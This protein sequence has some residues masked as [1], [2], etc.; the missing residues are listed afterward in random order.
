M[1]TMQ[2]MGL[3]ML[4]L[5]AMV[6]GAEA[7]GLTAAARV[8]RSGWA[9]NAYTLSGVTGRV[10]VHTIF[11]QN[12]SSSDLWLHVFDATS[13]PANNTRPA[14]TAVKILAGSGGGY[15][16][17]LYGAPFTSGV[18][19]CTSSTDLTLTNS[20]ASFDITTVYSPR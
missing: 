18:T 1:K 16:F 13:T 6:T 12:T 19:I 10:R 9:T 15:D 7:Q 5:V 20:T 14:L 17:G 3:M 4:M 2:W 8:E 11:V